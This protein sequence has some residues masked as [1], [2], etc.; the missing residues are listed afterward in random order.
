MTAPPASLDRGF[1]LRRNHFSSA[2]A[3]LLYSATNPDSEPS[4]TDSMPLTTSAGAPEDRRTS[5]QSATP[6]FA[7]RPPDDDS[8]PCSR[9][10]R[11]HGS[12]AEMMAPEASRKTM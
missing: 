7:R 1:T 11:F 2:D 5:R 8:W 9:A 4:S 3:V 12:F 6:I 10:K